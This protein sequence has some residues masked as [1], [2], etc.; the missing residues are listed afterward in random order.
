MNILLRFLNLWEQNA[1][2]GFSPPIPE[3]WAVQKGLAS[4]CP[5]SY[6]PDSKE[7]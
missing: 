2:F 5:Q 4:S 3:P 6:N 1:S 7:A